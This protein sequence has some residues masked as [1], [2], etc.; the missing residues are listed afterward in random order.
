MSAMLQ[1][2]LLFIGASVVIYGCIMALGSGKTGDEGAHGG[3]GGH[4]HH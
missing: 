2:V 1:G 4:G 3:H